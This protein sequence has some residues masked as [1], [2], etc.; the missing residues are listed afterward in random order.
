MHIT[1]NNFIDQ[2]DK[3]DAVILLEGKRKDVQPSSFG[4]FYDDLSDMMSGGT[5]H[6]INV[7]KVNNIPFIDQHTWL[8]WL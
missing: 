2:Y 3:K 1:L 7:C 6:T 5:G 8:N 4:I